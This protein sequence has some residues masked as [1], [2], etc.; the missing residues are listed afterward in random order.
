MSAIPLRTIPLNV[1]KEVCSSC[2]PYIVTSTVISVAF[3]DI[4]KYYK[5]LLL[6]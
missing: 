6:I 1:Y 2:T 4:K 5:C 3:I